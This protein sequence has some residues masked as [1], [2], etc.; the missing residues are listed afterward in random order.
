MKKNLYTILTLVI[1]CFSQVLFAQIFSIGASGV[2]IKNGTLL[3]GDG[4]SLT[5]SADITLVNLSLSKSTSSVTN[6]AQSYIA[7]VYKFSKN[8]TSFSGSVRVNFMDAELNGIT[9]ANLQLNVHDGSKWKTYSGT[10]NTTGNYVLSNTFTSAVLNELTLAS[11]ASPLPLNWLSFTATKQ[12]ANVLL[13]WSTVNE[14]NCKDFRVQLSS[15]GIRWNE[16]TILPAE[17]LN[18]YTQHYHYLHTAPVNSINYYRILQTDLDGR[19]SYSVLRTVKFTGNTAAFYVLGNPV[20]NGMLQ[21][22]VN[23]DVLL[24]LYTLDG[25]LLWQQQTTPGMKHIAVSTYVAGL[26]LL[27]GNDQIFKII[28]Q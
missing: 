4:L 25:K 19:S 9:K 20:N 2:T 12:K 27:K 3:Y 17:S 24:G 21:V 15:D 28:V 5:P 7:R 11:N 13:E 10:V 6:P 23:K 18:S 26:Y 8:I 16:L 22:Q 1:T 14:K